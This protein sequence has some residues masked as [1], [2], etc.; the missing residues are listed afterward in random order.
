MLVTASTIKDSAANV[1]FF[2]EANLASG[3][4]H[5]IVFLDAPAEEGQGEVE[6]LLTAHPHVTCVRAGGG[7][8]WHG[9]RPA[10]LNHR[11]RINA[12]WAHELLAPLGWA[13]WLAHV[14][15]DEVA[16]LDRAALTALP[17]SVTAVRMRP[18]EAVA[19]AG[20]EERSTLFKELL[21]DADLTLLQV[22]GVLDE[23]SNQGYFHGHVMGK[24]AIRVGGSA[25]LTLHD[26]VAADGS[27]V[28]S[29]EDPAFTVLHYDA[30]TE[31]EFV[32]K[33]TALAAAGPAR[34]RASRQPMAK[35]LRTLIGRD[36]PADVRERYLRRIY[37]R[38]IADD[39]TTLDELG[40]LVTCDPT[41]GDHTPQR[42]TEAQA[43]A[44][45]QR[46]AELREAP[47]SAYLLRD[48]SKD[49]V[50]DGAAEDD[51]ASR[52]RGRWLR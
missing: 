7:S 14:D 30:P 16:R 26:A 5:L 6:A 49:R 37:E 41:A 20:A 13:T 32:R 45:T 4:D 18:L 38:T 24:S 1:R 21:D 44:L 35:A 42:L 46:V 48:G 27:R 17:D 9:E 39:V 23:A 22:L 25:G 36:L 52:R 43:R 50:R 31:R 19:R 51:G 12:N 28:T 15:G 3:V 34:Y 2:V 40:L 33:W 29:T 8:W 10:N 47:K 11:Q